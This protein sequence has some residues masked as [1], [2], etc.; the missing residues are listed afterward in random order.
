M[1]K[2]V[3][4]LHNVHTFEPVSVT[5][6]EVL[7]W[8]WAW[9][10]E[11]DEITLNSVEDARHQLRRFPHGDLI[12]QRFNSMR[13]FFPSTRIG[14]IRASIR[15]GFETLKASR[16]LLHEPPV[17][18]QDSVV[19]WTVVFAS[20]VSAKKRY[21]YTER[22]CDGGGRRLRIERGFLRRVCFIL[23][24][25]LP[26]AEWFVSAGVP[27]SRIEVIPSIYCP[28]PRGEVFS[29]PVSRF[30]WVGR[31]MPLKGLDRFVDAV[32]SIP[33][34]RALVV[35]GADDGQ[36]MGTDADYLHSCIES[37]RRLQSVEIREHVDPIEQ[38]FEE[39]SVLVVPN[40]I[41]ESER[42]SRESWGRVVEEALWS[43]IPVIATDAVPAAVT[44]IA[45]GINGRVIS[46]TDD[47][48]L[49]SAM[50]DAMNGVLL[51]SGLPR[52]R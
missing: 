48:E 41:I 7:T 42:V 40:R 49:R 37:I 8:G 36:F 17:N 20:L 32:S 33:G 25:G 12:A 21:L 1:S 50:R 31:P 26:Q 14:R 13:I 24:P 4:T 16:V 38:V 44:L 35:L 9:S 3:S 2:V 51:D 28:A 43:G 34:A 45:Q 39:G 5:S 11:I 46:S 47:D 15:M 19:Y 23:V 18:A 29:G 27:R 22:W 10:S 6:N 30:L 52:V